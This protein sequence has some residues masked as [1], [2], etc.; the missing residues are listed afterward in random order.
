MQT[1]EIPRFR[2]WDGSNHVSEPVELPPLVTMVRQHKI[3][4]SH[5]IYE[6]HNQQWRS[7]GDIPE[8]KPL[9]QKPPARTSP[10]ARPP[11]VGVELSAGQLRRIKLLAGLDDRQIEACLQFAELIE[12][13][14]FDTVVRKG[15][16]SDAMYLILE[17]ELRARILVHGRETILATMETGDFFGEIS[18]LDHGPRSADVL[19]NTPS[20]LLRIPA[21]GIEKLVQESPDIAAP[22][23]LELA[24]SVVSRVRKLTRNYQ[25]SVLFSR[26]ARG[27]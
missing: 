6:E 24:R 12:C 8:L 9:F 26:T 10:S 20:R 11:G 23:L 25:D 1:D 27:S 3:A 21:A 2:V 14:Q 19:A 18:L 4:P 13:P 7:A 17:G 15:E 16:H 5:W 22:L